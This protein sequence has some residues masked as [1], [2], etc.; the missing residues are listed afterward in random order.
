M[1]W[2]D[3]DIRSSNNRYWRTSWASQQR[4]LAYLH[5]G[6]PQLRDITLQ[7]T[8]LCNRHCKTCNDTSFKAPCLTLGQSLRIVEEALALGLRHL[9]LTGGEPTSWPHL[10][11]LMAE[12]SKCGLTISLGSNGYFSNEMAMQLVE[13]GL[14]RLN[15]SYHEMM[16]PPPALSFFRSSPISVFINHVITSDN[17]RKLPQFIDHLKKRYPFVV[18]VQLMPPRGKAEKFTNIEAKEYF[19]QIANKAFYCAQRA[20]Y[21]NLAQKARTLL[22]VNKE[23]WQ[24]VKEGV[25]HKGCNLKCYATLTTMKIGALGYAPCTYLYRDGFA[26]LSLAHSVAEGFRACR[27]FALHK[28]PP[29]E[30]CLHSCGPELRNY[31]EIIKGHLARS[32]SHQGLR[33]LRKRYLEHQRKSA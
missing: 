15:L 10:L 24:L 8:G 20:G 29:H 30:M 17:F 1:D 14:S 4:I 3:I 32:K 31:N 5:G 22:G 7:V 19:M 33:R 18:D 23:Q 26:L 27:H 12:A 21:V 11:E 16:A 25:Y 9:H 2:S 6:K 13:R 28:A